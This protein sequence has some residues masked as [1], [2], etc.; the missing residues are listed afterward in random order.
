M[1][2]HGEILHH[3][4]LL[5]GMETEM[6]STSSALQDSLSRLG[7]LVSNG[8]S[9]HVCHLVV[10]CVVLFVLLYWLFVKG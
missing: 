2:M 6:S 7:V 3:N 8:G 10:F 1:D 4:K 9:L 5:S